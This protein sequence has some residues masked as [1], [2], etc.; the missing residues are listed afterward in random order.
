MSICDGAVPRILEIEFYVEIYSF[1][2]VCWI[3]IAL[4][5]SICLFFKKISKK[6]HYKFL[7]NLLGTIII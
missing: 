5:E 3:P 6:S 2:Y 4:L 7:K 1:L